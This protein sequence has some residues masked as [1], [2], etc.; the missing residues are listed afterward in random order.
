M[1]IRRKR[2]RRTAAQW[3]GILRR[4]EASGL[5][6]REFCRREGLSLSSLQRWRSK[7]PV[8]A[9]RARFVELTPAAPSTEGSSGWAVEIELPN[10]VAVRV[11]A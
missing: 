6:A 1:P 4:F 3:R 5:G 10:G 2:H 8:K 7:G 11:K 9:R